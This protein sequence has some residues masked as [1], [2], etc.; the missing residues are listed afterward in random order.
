MGSSLSRVQCTKSEMST[1]GGSY[2]VLYNVA[3]CCGWLYLLITSIP[4]V[5]RALIKGEDDG[6]LYR[7]TGFVLRLLCAAA[8]LEIAHAA[9][10]LVKSNPVITGFQVIARLF[11]TCAI[12][13][14]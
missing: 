9:C 11:V 6:Q 13:G 14:Y 7:E 12:L 4:H 8:L 1:L 10:G 5:G 2:L 3:Q